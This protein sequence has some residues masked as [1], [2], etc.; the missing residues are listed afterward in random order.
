M[1]LRVI[2]WLQKGTLI[3]AVPLMVLGLVGLVLLAPAK[4]RPSVVPGP[5]HLGAVG[6]GAPDGYALAAGD[7]LWV[8]T[9]AHSTGAV[10]T[11]WRTDLEVHN[12]GT[13]MAGYSIALLKRNTDNGAPDVRSFTLGPGQS[14]RYNDIILN[15]FGFSGA[16]AL[17]FT[18]TAGTILITSRTYN[19][20]P[21]GTYGQYVPAFPDAQAITYSEEGRLIQLGHQPDFSQGGSRTNLGLVN[22]GASPIDLTIDLYTAAGAWLG[23]VPV[24]LRA[25]EYQQLDQV[26]SQVISY[27]I[28]DGYAIV[29][30]SSANGRFFAY[31]SVIDNRTSDP[32]CVPAQ[33]SAP[34]FVYGPPHSISVNT[35]NSSEVTDPT[36]G[37]IFVFPQ[38]GHGMLTTANIITPPYQ[39]GSDGNGFHFQFTGTELVEFKLPQDAAAE[40]Q[41]WTY[42]LA[43]GSFDNGPVK[44]RWYPWPESSVQAG[45]LLF[46]VPDESIAAVQASPSALSAPAA[47]PAPL[48]DYWIR[49]ITPSSTEGQQKYAFV[50]QIRLDISAWLSKLSAPL[51]TAAQAEVNNSFNSTRV[52]N[53]PSGGGY[54]GFARRRIIGASFSPRITLQFNNAPANIVAHETGHLMNHL[55]VRARLGDSAGDAMYLRI[56][57][58][59]KDVHGPGDQ[60]YPRT[61]TTEEVAYLSQYLVMGTID[62]INPFDVSTFINYYASGKMPRTD[63]FPSLE[64]FTAILLAN[65]TRPTTTMKDWEKKSAEAPVYGAT[66]N[67]LATIVGM[68]ATNP[69][70]YLANILSER[71]P[72]G[73]SSGTTLAVNAERIGWSYHGFGTVT[74]AGS[75]VAG[76]KVKNIMRLSPSEEYV[77]SETTTDAGGNF[78][79]PRL[80][81]GWSQIHIEK[82]S[83]VTDSGLTIDWA[84]PT[85]DLIP[86]GSFTLEAPPT[87]TPTP[88]GHPTATVSPPSGSCFKNH[89]SV[90]LTITATPA[91]GT[92]IHRIQ[93]YQVEIDGNYFLTEIYDSNTL[94][95]IVQDYTA[96]DTFYAWVYDNGGSTFKLDFYYTW[97]SSCP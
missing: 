52:Y 46:D 6:G 73:G 14:V 67:D 2:H 39:P 31:A 7:V 40:T 15:V 63:D 29:R 24:S 54:I 91:A 59:S 13:T 10:G 95:Y 71:S 94:T 88:G 38:G 64:G 92:S 47:T 20:Q 25:Y 82:D 43:H 28:D 1:T 50:Q 49:K 27:A 23:Q 86:L 16:A 12:P 26:F 35:G 81:P 56:E 69:N 5:V 87:P 9:S 90:T 70:E 19:N 36:T 3:I 44:Q 45:Y 41:V 11:N 53:D 58:L 61:T 21:G 62:Q 84:T 78:Y 22:A 79:P 4:E 93:L 51:L 80:F 55:L 42:G 96:R 33:K 48:R 18:T 85:F 37:V 75:P 57:D 17:R 68:G 32:I 74:Q 72:G 89:T 60:F 66:W 8:A 97:S 83:A 77:A 34:A 65:L 30:T 76:A